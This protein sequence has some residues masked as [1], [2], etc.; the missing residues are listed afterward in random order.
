MKRAPATKTKPRAP[1]KAPSA[2]GRKASVT[3]TKA[4]A[5]GSPKAAAALPPSF[6]SHCRMHSWLTVN[7][8]SS[9]ISLRSRSVSLQRSRKSATK[10][11]MSL[12]SDTRLIE[13]QL[14]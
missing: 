4:R 11:T 1:G 13:Q 12:G 8:C 10:A 7:P 6:A 2:R 9:M 3:S 5:A 14:R